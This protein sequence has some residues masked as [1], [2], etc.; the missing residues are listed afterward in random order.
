MA[1][2]D[3]AEGQDIEVD[4]RLDGTHVPYRVINPSL[5][6]TVVLA[7][8]DRYL[9]ERQQKASPDIVMT[10]LGLEKHESHEGTTR[11]ARKLGISCR[12]YVLR[13]SDEGYEETVAILER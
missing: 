1:I 9:N 3:L 6:H 8:R 5:G 13:P 10:R 11:A 4:I 2:T 7:E 12:V